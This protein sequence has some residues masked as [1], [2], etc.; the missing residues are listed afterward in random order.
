MRNKVSTAITKVQSL[1][2]SQVEVF[3]S[4]PGS[5]KTFEP[6]MPG[7]AA[8][9]L[10]AKLARAR[11]RACKCFLTH[12]FKPL[13]LEDG[14]GGGVGVIPPPPV[15]AST[16]VEIAIPIAVRIDAMV[17][18]CSR[19]RVRM[20]L[21]SVVSSLSSRL[22]VSRIRFTWDLRASLFVER[23]FEPRLSFDFDIYRKAHSRSF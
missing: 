3:P 18:P 16:R 21:A 22:N 12:S 23:A 9:A 1:S 5:Q 6:T 2:E 15:S 10:P 13:L 19:K 4:A 14:F 20:R 7:R 11:P 17:I 8:A